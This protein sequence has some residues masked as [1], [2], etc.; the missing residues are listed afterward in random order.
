[1]GWLTDLFVDV[2]LSA[3]LREKLAAV[4]AENDALK[5]DNLILRDDLRETKAQT[6]RLQKQLDGYTH[7]AELDEADIRILKEV[8]LT[9][10]PAATYLSKK[11]NIDFGVIDFRLAQLTETDYLSAWSIGGV[12]RYSLRPKGREYLIMHNLV[13]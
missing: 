6:L 12:E 3:E 13:S 5:T 9:S 4:E 7:Q 8:A 2:P 1:M 10:E 11:L